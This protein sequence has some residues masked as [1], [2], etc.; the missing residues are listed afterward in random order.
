MK[1]KSVKLMTFLVGALAL[2]IVI[3]S[4][5]Y[6]AATTAQSSSF[7]DNLPPGYTVSS[8]QLS[9]GKSCSCSTGGISGAPEPPP[10]CR[11]QPCFGS[12]LTRYG[13]LK[14]NAEAVSS[15]FCKKVRTDGKSVPPC[16][17]LDGDDAVVISGSMSPVQNLT[18]YSLTLY[19]AFTYDNRFSSNYAPLQSSV[20]L[21]PNN[22]N[23]KLGRSGKYVLI[24]TAS[25]R[26]LDVVQ[27]ALRANGVPDAIINTYLIP[28]S[29]AN[30][31]KSDFPDQ[32]SLELRLTPQ[33]EA[34]KQ[35]VN[36]FVQETAPNTKVFFIRGPGI[37]GD[38]TF[39]D[40]PKW[41]DNIRATDVEYSTGLDQKLTALE[42]AVT[43]RYAQQG[44]HLK[45]RIVEDVFRVDSSVCRMSH[46]SCVFDSPDALYSI[47]PCDFS[48]SRLRNGNCKIQLQKNSND[49]LMLLGVNHSVVGDK[50]L[51][52][53]FSVE[54]RTTSGSRDGTFSF[55][56]LDTQGSA[57]QYLP[58]R[59]ATNLYAVKIARDCGSDSYCASAPSLGDI[60]DPTGFYILGRIY[61]DK[62]TGTAP[63]PANLVP[64]VI[65]WF[66]KNP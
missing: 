55:I 24:I 61:L 50:T 45:A 48:P 21:S 65:V 13:W 36:T 63:N 15:E 49:V 57:N 14:T 28:T 34:E 18:Y 33:G 38:V 32:L 60:S 9:M 11:T 26:T 30:V 10:P 54:S 6:S 51:A 46:K 5:F 62:V 29:V 37:E 52:A 7:I 59:Q 4:V 3:F 25:T 41:E 42:A 40:I 22:A 53:Y 64:S 27:K 31:G 66:T 8:G 23:L 43:K 12:S 2:L 58:R 20:S 56:G 39:D 19:Q 16:F 35:Q 44:Y 1:S 17:Q 47:F